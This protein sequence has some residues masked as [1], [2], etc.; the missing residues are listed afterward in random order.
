[1]TEPSDE[2]EPLAD[3]PLSLPAP[4]RL[5]ID[6]PRRDEILAAHDAALATGSA[7]YA[8][9]ATRLFV[10]TARFLADRGWCCGNGCRH[11]PYTV[12]ETD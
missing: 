6:D 1:M 9:P 3:R 10:L 5:A 11:C 2:R 7:G 12:A 8:D 4:W